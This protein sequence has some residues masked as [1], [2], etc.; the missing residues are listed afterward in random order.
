MEGVS[1]PLR[2]LFAR[3]AKGKRKLV[4]RGFINN[5][6]FE[7]QLN[8]GRIFTRGLNDRQ[9]MAENHHPGGIERWLT[10]AIESAQT[11]K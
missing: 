6:V 5:N 9:P 4:L 2:L 7:S 10:S 1:A 11:A 3:Q 8:T